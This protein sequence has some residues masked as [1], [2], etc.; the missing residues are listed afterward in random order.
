MQLLGS[1]IKIWLSI[2]QL[3]GKYFPLSA[4]VYLH[5]IYI[6]HCKVIILLYFPSPGKSLPPLSFSLFPS[7]ESY[8]QQE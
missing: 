4:A 8:Y 5:S 1:K 6:S 3:P 7:L 2:A